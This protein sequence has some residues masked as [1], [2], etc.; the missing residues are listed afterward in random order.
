MAWPNYWQQ[1]NKVMDNSNVISQINLTNKSGTTAS[2]LSRD[3][4]HK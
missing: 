4:G 2:K 3:K 1:W